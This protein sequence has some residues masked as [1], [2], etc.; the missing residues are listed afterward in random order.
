MNKVERVRAA[1]EGR[2]PDRVP[3]AFWSHLPG[4]DR[5]PDLLAEATVRLVA[6]YDIDLV[7]TMS[8]GMYEIEDFGCQCDF[9]KVT[10][11]GVA[12][13]VSTPVNAP[14]DWNAIRPLPPDSP[15]L[16]RELRMLER[17]LRELKGKLPVIFTVFSPLTLAEK[18]SL[19]KVR[20]HLDEGGGKALHRALE[21]LAGTTRELSREAI[22]MGADG[23]FYATQV[24]TARKFTS[25]EHREYGKP[26]DLMA[27]EG[28]KEG[29]CNVVHL[30]GEDV[31]FDD[32]CDYPVQVINWHVW[33]T[34]PEIASAMKKTGKCLMGGLKRF[35]ITDDKKDE[36]SAQIWASLAQSGGRRHI[37]SPGCVIRLPLPPSALQHVGQTLREASA[38]LL[39]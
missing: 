19:G 21:A 7:K 20:S 13:L 32:F 24:A 17:V 34:A 39:N 3:C 37:L 1:V 5:D 9:S 31:Y 12:E 22:K 2:A 4:I 38:S 33:E 36:I 14:E 30:H 6:D 25:E 16:G 8:N 11:G 10:S 27:L 18:L 23:V 26:Y 28:A 35:S 15:A 29:W